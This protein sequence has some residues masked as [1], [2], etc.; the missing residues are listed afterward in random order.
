MVHGMAWHGPMT[1]RSKYNKYNGE[2]CGHLGKV[3]DW[4]KE[5]SPAE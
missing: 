2:W 4:L 1:V 3:Q 5:K